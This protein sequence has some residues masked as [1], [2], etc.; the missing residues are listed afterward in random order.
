MEDAANDTY[1]FGLGMTSNISTRRP[2]HP[3]T[4]DRSTNKRRHQ[5]R[6]VTKHNNIFTYTFIAKTQKT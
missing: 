4:A 6:L 5:Q 3:I 1:L 2:D